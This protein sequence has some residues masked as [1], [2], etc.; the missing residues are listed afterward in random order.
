MPKEVPVDLRN[1][2]SA[3]TVFRRKNSDLIAKLAKETLFNEREVTQLAVLHK[4]ISS[5]RGPLTRQV[6][7]D[8]F[9]GGLDFTENLR[10]LL[11]DRIYGHFNKTNKLKL[12]IEHW[13]SGLSTIFRAPLPDKT[14]FA[15]KIYDLMRSNKITKEQ[16]FP[17]LRGC[18]IKLPP[19]DDADET[20]R[21]M[22]DL[23]L[24]SLDVDRDGEISYEDFSSVVLDNYDLYLESMGPVFPSREAAHAFMTTFTDELN[25]F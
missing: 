4:K 15:Y 22:I 8:V 23:L 19:E 16:M 13:V 1:N 18:M 10:H 20:V 7:R 21:D 24:K 3:E 11:I 14:K 25:K 2:S 9:H 17:M 12:P 6:F 5:T